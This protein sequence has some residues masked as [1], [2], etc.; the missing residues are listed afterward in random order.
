MMNLE[1]CYMVQVE[2]S[3]YLSSCKH[4]IADIVDVV[5]ICPHILADCLQ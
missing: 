5:E 3:M 1:D 4:T 2:G